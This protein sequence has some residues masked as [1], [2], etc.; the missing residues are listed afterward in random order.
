MTRFVCIHGHFYQPARENPWLEAVEMQDSA[1]P[2]HDWNE[3]I[4]AECYAP[5]FCARRHDAAGRVIGADNNY[6]RI[7]FSFGSSLLTYM[8][9]YRPDI[10]QALLQAD[11]ESRKTF[12]G[13][14]AAIAQPFTHLIL[15]L[16]D[17]RDKET[18]VNWGL[19]D[20][21]QRFR[22]P[23]E[24]MWL[25]DAAVDL[26]TLEVLAEHDVKFTILA[27]RQA[28]AFRRCGQPGT[29]DSRF[30]YLCRLPSG[31]A[32][33]LF[34]YDDR[35]TH[36][37]MRE[38]LLTN[39]ETFAR[40]VTAQLAADEKRP[41]LAHVSVDGEV[42]GHHHRF[43]EMALAYGLDFIERSDS[44][45]L[46][47]YG[48][49]LA[50]SPPDSEVEILEVSSSSCSHG[51]DRWRKN[52]G[53]NSGNFPAWNQQW[54]APLRGALDWLRD[55]LRPLMDK[56]LA[57]LFTNPVLAWK[58]YVEVHHSRSAER[59]DTFFATHQKRSLSPE[60]R[61]RALKSLELGRNAMH[62]YTSCG[63]FFDEISGLET[64]QILRFSARAI[65]LAREISGID[66][67]PTFERLLAQAP[68]NLPDIP[69]GAEVYQHF[70]RPAVLDLLRVGVHYAILS[71]F[72]SHQDT[73]HVYAFDYE[74]IQAE[75]IDVGRLKASI[76]MVKIR[77]TATHE[78]APITYAVV[79]LGDHNVYGGARLFLGPEAFT[80]MHQE[81]GAIVRTGRIPEILALI[82]R[83]FQTH[84]YSLW[85]L[86]QDDQRRV[87][88]ILLESV[89]EQV[90]DTFRRIHDEHSPVMRFVESLRIPFP[91]YFSMVNEFLFNEN[92]RTLL[93]ADAPDFAALKTLMEDSRPWA[94]SLDRPGIK[95]LATKKTVEV[96]QRLAMDSED[97]RHLEYC[98][99]MTGVIG[100]IFPDFDWWREQNI[101]LT[102]GQTVLPGMLL[103]EQSGDESS[104]IWVGL[105]RRL[106]KALN[107]GIFT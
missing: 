27:Q 13:H 44:A 103:R 95:Y 46:T 97:A 42:F 91:P 96:F 86:F 73:G 9:R 60:E 10:Y 78:E 102:L 18:Q 82:D 88:R 1:F 77:S 67:E 3:R 92:V 49:F 24:G 15:P 80:E 70:V 37:M 16:A 50:V 29:I 84:N 19:R 17:R 72:E 89:Y 2:F 31:K 76:G 98:L 101:F 20:F 74:S 71:I 45:R 94:Y 39:G 61:I 85:N 63:W 26:E 65:Q 22:R 107:M 33:S 57:E 69:N 38:G 54:R 7:S 53:C 56:A 30:P 35:I 12:N 66:L 6:G 59:V 21:E 68:G 5:N 58:E 52:C 93:A 55:N 25:P 23:A 36:A 41:Q 106:G 104:R 64:V 8:E 100:E 83:H 47:V 34:F 32:I 79:H 14:G 75:R 40:R 51:V 90:K 87:I 105:F 11:S 43:G 28:H 48:E 99:E 62:M 4:T 81:I